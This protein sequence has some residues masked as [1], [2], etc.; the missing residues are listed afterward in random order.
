MVELALVLPVLLLLLLGTV[1]F[2]RFF[3]TYLSL[4]HAAREG[5]RLYLTGASMPDVEARIRDTAY[6]VPQN[7]KDRI[8]ITLSRSADPVVG[9]VVRVYLSYPFAFLFPFLGVVFGNPVD[10]EVSLEMG[11]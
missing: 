6:L 7:E 5:A 8:A 2:G 1:E 10:V 3:G 11:V 4:Q 9:S